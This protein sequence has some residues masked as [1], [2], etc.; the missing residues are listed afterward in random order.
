M[1]DSQDSMGG[2]LDEMPNS[3]ESELKES[4]S[5][6]QSLKRRDGVTNSQSEFLTQNCSFLKELQGQKMEKKPRERRSS[7]C[8]N[9]RS[10]SWGDT[11]A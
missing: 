2:T 11:K 9:W 1:R 10:I 7:D 5:S 4:T 6:R 8:P 3:V